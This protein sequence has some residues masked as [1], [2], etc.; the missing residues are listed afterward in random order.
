MSCELREIVASAGDVDSAD[1]PTVEGLF[2]PS[3]S[4]EPGSRDDDPCLPSNALEGGW[5]KLFSSLVGPFLVSETP[6][7]FN[8]GYL[9]VR[10]QLSGSAPMHFQWQMRPLLHPKSKK[11]HRWLGFGQVPGC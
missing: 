5:R 11:Q 2:Q 4:P 7:K 3:C 8:H 1:H 10:C 6:E 9:G